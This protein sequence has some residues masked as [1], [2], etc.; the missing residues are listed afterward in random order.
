MQ[1]KALQK[2]MDRI[3]KTEKRYSRIEKRTAFVIGE[4][5]WLLQKHEWKRIAC[6]GVICTEFEKK[7][8][9]YFLQSRN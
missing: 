7:L 1:D 6:I 2:L 8:S 9:K 5:D 4:I 3:S